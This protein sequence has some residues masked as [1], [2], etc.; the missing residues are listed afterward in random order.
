VGAT[1]SLAERLLG[2]TPPSEA[3]V[4]CTSLQI[5][6]E[7]AEVCERFLFEG[8]PSDTGSANFVRVMGSGSV[9]QRATLAL[10]RAF[11]P[12]REMAFRYGVSPGSPALLLRYPMRAVELLGRYAGRALRGDPAAVRSLEMEGQRGGLVAWLRGV[13]PSTGKPDAGPVLG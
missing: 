9:R 12:P 13:D 10:A 7:I 1:F 5:G 2:W 8:S 3:V 6:P 4:G 11:L